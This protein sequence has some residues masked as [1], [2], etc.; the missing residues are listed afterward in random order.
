MKRVNFRGEKF[1]PFFGKWKLKGQRK[2]TECSQNVYRRVWRKRD[3]RKRKVKAKQLA[4]VCYRNSSERVTRKIVLTEVG[5]NKSSHANK[6]SR[7]QSWQALVQSISGTIEGN[8]NLKS[9][10]R[11]HNG[12]FPRFVV[13]HSVCLTWIDFYAV[14]ELV[15]LFLKIAC[16]YLCVSACFASTR[17]TNTR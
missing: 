11:E 8:S 1:S 4:K 15:C 13:F 14:I 3:E 17:I 9:K 7:C 5:K 10:P 12:L 2:T 16:T 6:A